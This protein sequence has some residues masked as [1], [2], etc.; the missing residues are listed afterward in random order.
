[1]NSSFFEVRGRLRLADR[2]LEQVSL[3]ERRGLTMVVL[4]RERVSSLDPG[5][6]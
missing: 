1:V 6:S 2:V 3:I 5:T 4:R